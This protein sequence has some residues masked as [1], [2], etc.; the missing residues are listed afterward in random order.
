MK[1]STV[2]LFYLSFLLFKVARDKVDE[3][4]EGVV[5]QFIF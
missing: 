4:V 1:D 5:N 3:F 2:L